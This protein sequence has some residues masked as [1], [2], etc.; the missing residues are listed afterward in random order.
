M[1]HAPARESRG[2][3]GTIQ[4]AQWTLVL[5]AAVVTG[6]YYLWAVRASGT[7][8]LWK[9]DL[10]GYYDLLGRGF[11]GGHL[12]VP[13]EPSPQLLAQPDPW[14]PSVD[15]ALKMHDMAL[16]NGR[17]YL[18]FGSTPAVLLFTPWRLITG[19][20]LP[21]TF[22]IFLLVFGGFL[23]ACGALLRILD[24][25]SAKPGPALLGI[26]LL[27]LGL[28]QSVPYLL[29][30]VAVYEIPI[31]GGYFCL[32]AAVFCVARGIGIPENAPAGGHAGWLA[33]AGLMYGCAVGC[34]P[35]LVFAGLIA[36]VGLIV[37]VPKSKRP[38]AVMRTRGVIAFTAAFALV[39]LAIA[40]YNYARFGNP[41]EFGF[42]Y[43]LSGPG[44]NRI[45]IATRNLLPGF[46]YML[47]APPEISPVFPW[48]RMLR[49]FVF[50]SP[51]RYPLPPLYFTEPTVGALWLA[52]FLA[53]AAF[54]PPAARA[55]RAANA[56]LR[57]VSLSSLAILL[58]LMSSHLSSHRYETDFVASAVFAAVAS[59]GIRIC[60]CSGWR[61]SMLTALVAVAIGYSS[62]ANLALGLAGPYDDV[63]NNRPKR[64][65]K[66]AGWFSPVRE[67]RPLMNPEIGLD[68]KVSFVRRDPGF[69]EP[70]IALGHSQ[71]VYFLFVEHTGRELRFLSETNESKAM[72]QTPFPEKPMA[73]RMSYSPGVH[74]LTIDIDGRT[75]IAHPI[76]TLVTAPADVRV[77]ENPR[78]V[79]RDEQRFTGTVE[80]LGKTIQ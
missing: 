80:I 33:A 11:A 29:N 12:Y 15:P 78:D 71:H 49:H 5:A 66:I 8:F 48:I 64:Y 27:G 28:C 77:G 72:Y 18:Y 44:Q 38:I 58:F 24:L 32:S 51:D 26:L 31:A 1:V 42:R 10:N 23:F 40:A 67:F 70:L 59:L 14:D 52:P 22:A 16:Y 34:R 21:E 62:V 75:V 68:L 19:H 69:R 6:A 17:Y 55:G 63:L 41:F 36:L 53:A 60:A 39:G 37:F 61:R 79:W 3:I 25:A 73:I 54:V 57:I 45:E 20:D 76:E 65:V 46:Y 47:I 35:H 50:D 56:I 74:V 9:Y 43:Q 7:Q 2:A 13:L 30:R 4:W